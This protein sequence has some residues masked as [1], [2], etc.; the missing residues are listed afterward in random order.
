MM[1]YVFPIVIG[2]VLVACGNN[3]SIK[4]PEVVVTEETNTL[5]VSKYDLVDLTDLGLPAKIHVPNKLFTNMEPRAELNEASGVIEI[6][7]GNKFKLRIH[8]TEIDKELLLADLQDDLLF[9]NTVTKEEEGLIVYSSELPD[10]SGQFEHFCAWLNVNG[11][12]FMIQNDG[13]EKF[14]S[15]YIDRMVNCVRSIQITSSI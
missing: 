5:D 6:S 9:K 8:E 15:H 1:K 13:Q 4:S 12:M 11:T 3:N 14:S 2:I 7:S 10:G